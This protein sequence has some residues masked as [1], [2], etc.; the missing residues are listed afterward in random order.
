MRGGGASQGEIFSGDGP[1]SG[2]G[3]MQ[4]GTGQMGVADQ[5]TLCST[6]RRMMAARTPEERQAMMDQPM[7][8]MSPEMQQRH[9]QMMA[10]QCK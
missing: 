9:L 1:Q 2:P 8:S 4:G 10:E 5:E 7:R 3:Y 6:Y